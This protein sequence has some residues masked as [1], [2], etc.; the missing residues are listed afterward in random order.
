MGNYIDVLER[1][2]EIDLN[3]QYDDKEALEK[4]LNK[5]RSILN[6]LEEAVPSALAE[7]G[8]T[9]QAILVSVAPAAVFDVLSI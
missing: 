8:D 5:Y 7:G 6:D 4:V 2:S 9:Q 1:L 3:A